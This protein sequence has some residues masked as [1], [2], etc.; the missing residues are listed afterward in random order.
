VA[1]G[2]CGEGVDRDSRSEDRGAGDESGE[3]KPWAGVCHRVAQAFQADQRDLQEPE[4]IQPLF[5]VPRQAGRMV[6]APADPCL[7]GLRGRIR[8]GIALPTDQ[9]TMISL[10]GIDLLNQ[11]AF[12]VTLHRFLA[13]P[14][15]E[16]DVVPLLGTH[17][18]IDG[19]NARLP[20]F[21]TGRNSAR[22]PF[23]PPPSGWTRVCLPE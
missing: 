9:Q 16:G 6:P 8:E 11:R 10:E 19:D 22:N 14:D 3:L 15:D 18:V 21:E 2:L 17:V 1:G 20:F 12:P 23:R 7:Y 13:F 5:G 4:F